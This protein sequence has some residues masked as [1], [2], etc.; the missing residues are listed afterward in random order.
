MNFIQYFA[1]QSGWAFR[2]L[3]EKVELKGREFIK[4]PVTIFLLKYIRMILR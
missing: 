1:K 4:I 2:D 3:N